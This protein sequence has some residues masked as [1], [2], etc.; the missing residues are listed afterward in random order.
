MIFSRKVRMIEQLLTR[1]TE[2][3]DDENIESLYEQLE[4]FK[5]HEVLERVEY[6]TGTVLEGEEYLT[7]LWQAYLLGE[8]QNGSSLTHFSIV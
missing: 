1:V 5:R 4:D 7:I 8:Q 6:E 2:A 3:T